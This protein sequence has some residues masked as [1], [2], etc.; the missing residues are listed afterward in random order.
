MAPRN[1]AFSLIVPSF[2]HT[3][4]QLSQSYGSNWTLVLR[5]IGTEM[6][7]IADAVAQFA[8]GKQPDYPAFA[9]ERLAKS[10]LLKGR[11]VF[12]T[13]PHFPSTGETLALS[14]EEV[15]ALCST[16]TINLE[17]L[18]GGINPTVVFIFFQLSH[19]AHIKNNCTFLFDARQLHPYVA[20]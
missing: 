13:L 2:F 19:I 9:D 15:G 14:S 12:L 10:S 16:F 11:W 17:F 5:T 4:Q 20:P 1:N 8:Q 6:A 3:L 7:D 18:A